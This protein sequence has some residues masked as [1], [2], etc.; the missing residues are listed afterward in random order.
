MSRKQAYF[1]I[2]GLTVVVALVTV[3]VFLPPII[4]GSGSVLSVVAAILSGLAFL[5]GIVFLI[6]LRPRTWRT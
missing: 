6:V 1:L 5:V 3:L 2:L 4:R